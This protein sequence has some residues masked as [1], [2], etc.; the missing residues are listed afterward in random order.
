[1]ANELSGVKKSAILLLSLEEDQ[2]A[3]ILRRL[4]P[5]AVEEVSREIASMGEIPISVRKDVFGEFY[6]LALANSS[7]IESKRSC[8]TVA[9]LWLEYAGKVS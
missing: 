7:E 1:M 2:A 5:D 4:P 8:A 9:Y 6:T 3:D